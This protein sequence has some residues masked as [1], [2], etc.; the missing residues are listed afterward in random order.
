[1]V[2]S[3]CSDFSSTDVGFDLLDS[4]LPQHAMNL[5]FSSIE[6]KRVHFYRER[7]RGDAGKVP[8]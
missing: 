6:E 2:P 7:E 1:M 3:P 8:H 5:K 4:S